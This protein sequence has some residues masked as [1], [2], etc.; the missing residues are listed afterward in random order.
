ML[1]ASAIA[2]WS[3][4]MPI[5]MTVFFFAGTGFAQFGYRFSLDFFPFLFL[6]IVKGIGDDLRWHHKLL[7]LL[8]VIVNLWGVVWLYQFDA[9]HYLAL[10]WVRT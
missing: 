1:P 5:V 8:G 3:A 2:C 4:I 9:H 10:R 7:I 6:L